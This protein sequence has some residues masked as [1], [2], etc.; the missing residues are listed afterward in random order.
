MLIIGR[1][2]VRE[3][4]TKKACLPLMERAFRAVSDGTAVQ[5]L[6]KIISLGD[7]DGSCF[8]LMPGSLQDPACFGAKVTSVFPGNF[9]SELQSHQ[10]AVV[11][12]ERQRGRPLAIVHAGEITAI[13]TA[14][15]SAVATRALARP[16]SATVAILGYG[17]QA[18]EHVEALACLE[19][20]KSFRVWGRSFDRA[21]HF[22]S[23]MEE[24]H[25][26]EARA[27]H[28]V[29]EA[30]AGADIACTLTAAATPILDR[31]AL[32][33]GM[34]LN[35]VGASVA[36]Y[37]EVEPEVVAGS[38]LFVDYRAMARQEAGEFIQAQELR[39]IGADHIAAEIGDVLCGRH[40]G[41]RREDEITFFK[42]LGMP[43][44]DLHAAYYVYETALT[45]KLGVHVDF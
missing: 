31:D 3:V 32:E 30:T 26:V 22:A 40:P 10:G 2:V 44:E 45:Q 19:T 41:R 8:G 5:E 27:A 36:R 42:S 35:V 4:L 38:T 43:A 11:L 23:R 25:G 24:A 39:L 18:A 9:G 14:S 28:S 29:R 20:I 37:R 34:H 1:D 15:A 13:R 16:G 12:F 21:S 7:A 17:E 33:P 6:R